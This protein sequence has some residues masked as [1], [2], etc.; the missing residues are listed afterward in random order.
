MRFYGFERSEIAGDDENLDLEIDPK[1]AWALRHRGDFPVDLNRADRERMLRVPG[2][3]TR[4]VERMIEVRR[5]KQLVLED[6]KRLTRG[7]AKLKPFIVTADWRPGALTD[8]ADLRRRLAP[9]PSQPDLF[10]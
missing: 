5:Y 3:G 4:S 7:L 6:V 10:G 8:Q 1:L 2:L 9:P